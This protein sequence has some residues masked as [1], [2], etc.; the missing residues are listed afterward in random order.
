MNEATSQPSQDLA[1]VFVGGYWWSRGETPEEIGARL[2]RWLGELAGLHDDFGPW[3]VMDRPAGDVAML[4]ALIRRGFNPDEET[5]EPLEDLGFHVFGDNTPTGAPRADFSLKAGAT[6]SSVPN[7]MLLES[8]YREPF[9]R[10]WVGLA[11]PLIESVARRWQPD[12]AVLTRTSYIR[13]TK[14]LNPGQFRKPGALTWLPVDPDQVPQVAE[15][16]TVTPLAGGAL[17]SLIDGETMPEIDTVLELTRGL[18]ATGL[19]EVNPGNDQR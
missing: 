10:E 9:P 13:A 19:L 1:D 17:I 4:T 3:T 2:H 6:A 14:T 12:V 18:M 11:V 15:A 8:P 5:G 7:S 16:Q